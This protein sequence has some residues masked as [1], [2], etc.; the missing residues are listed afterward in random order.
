MH[1]FAL[2]LIVFH[3]VNGK[4]LL[5]GDNYIPQIRICQAIGD[6]LAQ[7][8]KKTLII[9]VSHALYILEKNNEKCWLYFKP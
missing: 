1:L 9:I 4:K 7:Y 3:E 6:K 2:Q 5:T 8:L